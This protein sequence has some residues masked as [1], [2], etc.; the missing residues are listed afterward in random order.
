MLSPALMT[1]FMKKYFSSV[2]IKKYRSASTKSLSPLTASN[3]ND[4][5]NILVIVTVLFT[6]SEIIS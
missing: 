1:I 4:I 6:V 2:G 3:V 5:R